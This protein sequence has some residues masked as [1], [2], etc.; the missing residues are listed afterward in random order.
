CEHVWGVMLESPPPTPPSDPFSQSLAGVVCLTGAE[1][2][3]HPGHSG[4]GWVGNRHHTHTHTHT[5]T[6]THTHTHTHT[7]TQ[8]QT[9]SVITF[10]VIRTLTGVHLFVQSRAEMASGGRTDISLVRS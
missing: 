5:H 4:R 1:A 2:H 9:R 10:V 6:L 3:S 8:T 7:H